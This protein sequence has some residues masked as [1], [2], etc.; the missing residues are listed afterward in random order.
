[1]YLIATKKYLTNGGY[2]KCLYYLSHIKRKLEIVGFLQS[3]K[4]IL[5]LGFNYV[6]LTFLLDFV[7]MLD[8]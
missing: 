7:L 5:K 2:I 4:N 3:L 6:Y 1:M 8:T